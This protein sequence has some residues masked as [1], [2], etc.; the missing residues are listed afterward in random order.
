MTGT[1]V[2]ACR[3][4][5][6]FS[7]RISLR[8]RGRSWRL[9]PCGLRMHTHRRG[10][11][12][13]KIGLGSQPWRNS[14]RESDT[15]QKKAC[16]QRLRVSCE[17][18]Q[19]SLVVLKLELLGLHLF[20]FIPLPRTLAF[21]PL[22]PHPTNNSNTTCCLAE[23]SFSCKPQPGRCFFLNVSTFLTSRYSDRSFSCSSSPAPCNS[24]IIVQ[25]SL[26]CRCL[27]IHLFAG[28]QICGSETRT[29]LLTVVSSA[30]F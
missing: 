30:C 4:R 3:V 13:N 7:T 18:L 26:H 10:R 17:E 20:L 24:S 15:S 21:S 2:E 5:N 11:G 27:F 6:K 19:C 14:R 25:I 22:C 8:R 16:L 29:I 9:L 28:L 12:S 1:T 23:A